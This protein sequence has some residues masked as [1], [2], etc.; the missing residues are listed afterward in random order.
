MPK[1]RK[2]E[3]KQIDQYDHKEAKRTDNPFV[4]LVTQ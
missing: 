4:E 3:K 1:H 2:S